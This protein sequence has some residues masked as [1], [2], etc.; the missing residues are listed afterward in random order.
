[1]TV[2]SVLILVLAAGSVLLL[3]RKAWPRKKPGKKGCG[4]G[5]G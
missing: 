3:A 2:Q 4:C 5:C 1:M